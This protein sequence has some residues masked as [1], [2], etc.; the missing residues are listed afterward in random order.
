MES[1][2][3]YYT[4]KGRDEPIGPVSLERLRALAAEGAIASDTPVIREGADEWARYRDF[5][6][7]ERTREVAEVMIDRAA[8]MA[9]RLQTDESRSFSLG[10]LIGLVRFLTLPWD[11][12]ARATRMISEWGAA[13]FVAIPVD[14]LTSATLGQIAAPMFVLLWTLLWAGD[15]I[16][17]L[18]VGRPSFSVTL[19]SWT[20]GFLMMGISQNGLLG[21]PQ[22]MAKTAAHAAFTNAIT[23]HEFD[24]RLAWAIKIGCIGYFM[25]I[26]WAIIGEFFAG[27]AALIGLR[28]KR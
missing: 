6:S 20:G 26:F 25:T 12:V 15:C 16:C 18:I 19:I 2:K 5:H 7:G 27:L 17:M 22:T 13:R 9:A 14:R 1:M 8:R 3:Y 4:D 28:A 23:V 10:F 11:I 24:D 21:L